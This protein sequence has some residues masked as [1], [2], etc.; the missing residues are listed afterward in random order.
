M[1]REIINYISLFRVVLV[2]FCFVIIDLIV[3]DVVMYAD[4]GIDNC[5]LIINSSVVFNE[6]VWLI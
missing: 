3:Y 2:T 6:I 1:V 4:D 5:D